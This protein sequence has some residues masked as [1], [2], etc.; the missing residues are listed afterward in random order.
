[1]EQINSLKKIKNEFN[2]N[3]NSHIFLVETNDQEACIKDIKEL[4][5][6][7]ISTTDE[8]TRHQ[9]DEETYLELIII[10][11]EDKDIKKDQILNLL[12]RLKTKPILSKNI[13]YIITSAE[14][15]NET[16]ANKLLKTIE[17][18]NPNVIGFLIT[19]KSDLI[20][21]TIKSRCETVDI[22][23]ET[24]NNSVITEEVFDLVKSLIITIETNNHRDFYKIKSDD[25][26]IK[27]NAQSIEKLLKDYYNTACN[28]KSVQNIDE[29][30]VNM[31]K[32]N[33]N[34]YKI[35]KKTKYLNETFNKLTRN[36]NFDLLLEKIFF[37]LRM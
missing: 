12:E 27:E 2:E 1:M 7:Q 19:E 35:I 31:I 17:E 28:M 18:P 8:I 11:K 36:M 9:I 16:A 3:I 13:Y 22:L 32:N 26:F 23:Y 6:N 14:S 10:R 24:K 34:Y 21:P 29:N 30:T 5:K 20:L 33:N 37:E 25:K 4:I 15:M